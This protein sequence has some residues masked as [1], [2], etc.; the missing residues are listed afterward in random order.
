MVPP[1]S[2]W[3]WQTKT[4]SR[5][6]RSSGSSSKASR[7]PAGPW[8]QCDSM[9]RAT[10]VGAEVDELHVDAEIALAEQLDHRLE[11]IAI[12]AGDPHKVA[13]DRGLHLELAVLDLL[14]DLAR[15]LDGDPL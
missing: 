11:H 5:G 4:A 7:R 13:L 12:L 10:S 8:I 6:S 2:G 9:R 14:D 3:G 15:L 1:W